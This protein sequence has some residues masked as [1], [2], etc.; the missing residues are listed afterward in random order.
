MGELGMAKRSGNWRALGIGHLLGTAMLAFAV[1]GSSPAT[2]QTDNRPSITVAMPVIFTT[3]VATQNTNFATRVTQNIYDRLIERD[4]LS[5]KDGGGIKPVPALATA[6]KQIS[7]TVLEITLRPNVKFHNGETMTAEDVAFTLS[8]ERLW[9]PKPTEPFSFANTI[10]DVTVVDPLTV[11][12][13]TKQSDPV[14][15]Q[16]LMTQMS[17]VVPKKYYLEVGVDKF[18]QA[19]IGTGP[20]RW[21]KLVQGEYLELVAFDDYWGGKPPLKS[22]TFRVVPETSARIAGLLTGEFDIVT[23]LPSNQLAVVEKDK[24]TEV[25]SVQVENVQLLMFRSATAGR[26]VADKRVRQAMVHA[27]DRQL[28]VDRLWGGMTTVPTTFSW[29]YLGDYYD[30]ARKPRSYDPERAKKLLAEA[31]YKGEQIILRNISGYYLNMDRAVQV[32]LEMWKKVG[33]NV[34]LEF[35]ENMAQMGWATADLVAISN[36]FEMPD[37]LAPLWTSWGAAEGFFRARGHWA[38]PQAFLD[39]GQTLQTSF[40][41][42]ERRVA[43]QKMLDIWEDETPAIL[44]YR[45][46]ESY[47]VR[48]NIEWRPYTMYWMDFRDFNFRKK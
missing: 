29:P 44:L 7:P 2:A 16:R 5:G 4:W 21:N 36:N 47:G 23:S 48:K 20:Y 27:I 40:D 32:M 35:V 33:L 34:K 46:V 38:P 19:P 6:W 15:V 28:L 1:F 3:H 12:I 9:G 11:R 25:R 30:K 22:I 13:T 10:S 39:L 41:T 8:A 18:G 26:P 42:A 43:Y 17:M 37:P 24:A 31:G 14:I 45:P